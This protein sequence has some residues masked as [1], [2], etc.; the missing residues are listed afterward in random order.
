M[1]KYSWAKN[2]ETGSS[3]GY[4]IG[5]DQS[6]RCTVRD[7]YIHSTI[8]PTPAGAGYGLEFSWGSADNLA[9]NNISWNFD[10]VMVMRASGGGKVMAYNCMDDGWIAHQ[11][12][13]VES[14]INAAHMTMPHF[15]LFERNLTFA[16][17]TDDTWGGSTFIT[18]LRNV[19]TDHRSAWPPLNTYVYNTSTQAEGGCTPTGPLDGN[20]IPY[21]DAGNRTTEMTSSIT[22]A[23]SSVRQEC[24]WLPSLRVSHTPTV[25]Q[26]GRWIRFRCGWL[27]SAT[28]IAKPTWKPTKAW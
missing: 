22:S 19:A 13:W 15:E 20:C 12:N 5:I 25:P 24:P 7:S 27:A 3:N 9:E 11:P 16:L 6:F 10:K 4:G 26:T 2:I 1:A 14:G 8:N 17:G 23:T 28:G 21:T 18:W